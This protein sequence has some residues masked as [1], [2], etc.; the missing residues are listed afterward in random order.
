MQVY[1]KSFFDHVPQEFGVAHVKAHLK[2]GGSKSFIDLSGIDAPVP[3]DAFI[4]ARFLQETETVLDD[5][6]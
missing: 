2:K 6:G 1:Q 4:Y 3:D 5:S